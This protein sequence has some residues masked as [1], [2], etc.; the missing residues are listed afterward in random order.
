MN[1][2]S[3]THKRAIHYI[4]RF[5]NVKINSGKRTDELNSTEQL[6]STVFDKYPLN[7]PRLME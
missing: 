7:N 1:W 5:I 6:I 3:T 4:R 2:Y